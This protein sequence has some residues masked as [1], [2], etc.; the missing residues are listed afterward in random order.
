MKLKLVGDDLNLLRAK[1]NRTAAEERELEKQQD[2][3]Q[4]LI[5]LRD[6][7]LEIAPNYKPNHDDGVQITAAPLWSLFRHKPWQKV[8]KETWENLEKGEY[9]WAHLA[10]SYWP[11][12][13]REKCRI[14]KSLAIAHRSQEPYEEPA[15]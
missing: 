12:R 7:I 15:A 8:L 9:D 3:D 13:V 1:T 10:Y 11:D 2:L 6:T 14:D 5:E 4:E